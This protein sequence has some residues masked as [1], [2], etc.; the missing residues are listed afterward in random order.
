MIRFPRVRGRLSRVILLLLLALPAGSGWS[1]GARF[2]DPAEGEVVRAQRDLRAGR[3]SAA[4]ATFSQWLRSNPRDAEAQA[5][6]LTARIETGQYREAELEAR[7]FLGQ[8]DP[9]PEIRLRLGEVLALTGREAEA[10]THF[11]AAA[12]AESSSVRLRARLELAE[13]KILAG[14]TDEARPLLESLATY[15]EDNVVEEAVEL[16]T[17]ARAMIHL[18]KFQ[19][20]N[21]L[22]LEAIASDKEQIEGHLGGG[23]L[24]TSKYN[25]AEAAAFFTD[26]LRLNENSARAHLGVALNKRVSGGE[27]MNAALARALK[28]NP[29][30]V[31]ARTFAATLDL[32]A[33]RLESARTQIDAALAVNPRALETRALLAALHWLQDRPVEME[34][35]IQAI[36][37]INPRDGGLYEV[38]AH[39]ATQTRRYEEAVGF[40][41]EAVR[42]SPRRWSAHMALGMGLLRLGRIEEGRGALELAFKG[43][44]FNLWAKNSLDLLDAMKEYRELKSDGFIIRTAPAESGMIA[45][46]AAELLAEA[47]RKLSAR[48]GFTPRTPI[49]VEIFANHEDFA[50][51]T[52]GLPGLGALGV[53]FGQVIAQDSPTARAGSPFNWGSTLWHEFAHVIT[54][55]ITDHRIPR[56][57]SEGLSVYEEHQ[58][59]PGWG[60]DW[61]PEH[62]RAFA[63]GRWFRIADLDN[64]FIR[65]KRPDDIQLAYF[66][67]AQICHFITEKHG[68]EAILAML[69]GYREKKRTPQIL[70]EVLGLSEA[71]FDRRFN[72]YIRE[73]IAGPLQALASGTA[74]IDGGG[75]V[76]LVARASAAPES[77][78]LNLQ[79]G[80]T[81]YKEKNYDQAARFLRQAITLFPWQAGAGNPYELLATIHLERG[82]KGAASEMYEAWLRSDENSGVALRKLAALKQEAGDRERAVELLRLSFMIDPFDAESHTTAGRLLLGLNRAVEAG[83]EFETALAGKPAN[84]ADAWFDLARARLA[85]GQRSEAKQALLKSLELA[86][87]FDEGLELLLELTEK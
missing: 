32:E 63:A 78:E 65:P 82:E 72:L 77:Y 62:V 79:A 61:S 25:Y 87:T 60:D 48:Y 53:C 8:P 6:L 54:L 19:E 83:R 73:R 33:E 50:V 49:A 18:E 3:Y 42:L 14:A 28:I 4:I 41:N 7:R 70:Q 66:E 11:T 67:A 44:P 26:A 56:W 57:F 55:Q 10:A 23:E 45:G 34:R 58:A 27:E 29:N 22:Y 36:L 80:L 51:R 39:F 40:L 46:Y 2:Q 1:V 69:R 75:S 5:G 35:E 24:Y 74:P 15:Y 85:A 64:G 20:A 43:D 16:V 38:L 12:R 86:P 37:A 47:S 31:G 13:L 68:F 52:L 84:P 76:A 9:D 21:D 17:I 71:E 30:H 59:R 81:L